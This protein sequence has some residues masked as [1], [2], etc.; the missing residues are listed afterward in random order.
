MQRT[1]QATP[2]QLFAEATAFMVNSGAQ[3]GAQTENSV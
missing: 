2:E 3:V 1:V